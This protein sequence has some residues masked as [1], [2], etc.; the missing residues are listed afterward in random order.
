MNT[1]TVQITD[2]ALL[3][4]EEI[5][6]YIAVDLFL[7]DSALEQYNRIAQAILSLDIFPERCPLFEN[8]PEHTLGIRKLII[9][10]YIICFIIDS[11]NVTV[12]DVLYGAS[13]LHNK[14]VNRH[15]RN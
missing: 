4:M 15:N 13:N 10:N 3:D 8:E 2:E 14:L 1:F 5:Y 9:D 7:P 11:E 6:N 12:T